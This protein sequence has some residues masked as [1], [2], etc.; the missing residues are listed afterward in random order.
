MFLIL[1]IFLQVFQ[2]PRE[3]N[4]LDAV[5]N[6]FSRNIKL[7]ASN[8]SG[9]SGSLLFSVVGKS[10]LFLIPATMSKLNTPNSCNLTV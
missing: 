1:M 4:Q 7:A 10:H 8:T 5:L 6:D 3:A 9:C 2:E